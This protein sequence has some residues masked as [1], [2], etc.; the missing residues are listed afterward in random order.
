MRLSHW[1]TAVALFLGSSAPGLAET[2][3]IATVNNDD[4]TT[5]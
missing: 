5:M 2:I 1:A 3:T 4:M